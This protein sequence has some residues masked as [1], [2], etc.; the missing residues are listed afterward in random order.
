MQTHY[1]ENSEKSFSSMTERCEW[2]ARQCV[3]RLRGGISCT[4]ELR[5]WY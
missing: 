4:V 5:I 3:L 2:G 1:D